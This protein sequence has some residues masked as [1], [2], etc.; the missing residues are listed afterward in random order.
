MWEDLLEKASA[1]QSSILAGRIPWTEEPGRLKS[2][3][4]ESLTGLRDYTTT[5]ELKRTEDAG[6]TQK[7][8][9]GA[10]STLRVG[11]TKGRSWNY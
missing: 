1:A 6:R 2:M 3:G 8:V 11:G 7:L 10:A 9:L 4:S 5:I